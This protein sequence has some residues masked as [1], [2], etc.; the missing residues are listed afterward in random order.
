MNQTDTPREL[1]LFNTL[2]RSKEAFVPI[3]AGEALIYTCGPT[4]YNYAHI[5]NLRTYVFP[6][7]LKKLLQRLGYQVRQIV[8]FTDVGH[9]T[10]DQDAGDDKV[11]KAAAETGRSAWD[12]SRFYAEAY[13]RDIELLNIAFPSHFTYAT[14]YIPQQ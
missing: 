4:V 14:D 5:G 9:L 13:K 7:L 11:E 8:N 1:L 6:D 2:T 12:I 3:K 10:S